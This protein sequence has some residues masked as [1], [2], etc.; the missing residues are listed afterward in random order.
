MT[1]LRKLPSVTAVV[2]V[3]A[4]VVETDMLRRLSTELQTSFVDVEIVLVANGVKSDVSLM[5]KRVIEQVPDCT[6][7]FLN[8]EVHDDLARLIGIDHAISDYIMFASPTQNEI[9]SIAPM[10]AAAQDGNDLVVGEGGGFGVQRDWFARLAYSI[11]LRTFRALTGMPFES[12]PP[13]FRL[14]SRAAALFI[15]TQMNGE[16]LVRARALGQ[17]FPNIAVP[18]APYASMSGSGMPVRMAAGKGLR[19]VLTSSALPLRISSYFGFLSGVT[20]IL[21]GIYVVLTYFLGEGIARGWTTLSLQSVAITFILSI[22][23]L[24]LS[25][26]LVQILSTSPVATRRHLVA[27]ELRGTISSRSGRLNVVDLEG[28]FQIGAPQQLL[29]PEE[30]R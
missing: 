30:Q 9:D 3:R 11:F 27:R 21:Y 13:R 29:T 22:Q 7:V 17:G 20:S 25:E 19:L 26:Y 15:A 23:F 1:M 6:V 24:F 10:I 18:I 5:L 2:V 28:Q 14:L 8:K 4:F 16:V 12:Q